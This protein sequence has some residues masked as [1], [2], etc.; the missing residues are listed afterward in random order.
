MVPIYYKRRAQTDGKNNNNKNRLCKFYRKKRERGLVC[1]WRPTSI[2]IMY[3]YTRVS[4]S[5]NKANSPNRI[6]TSFIYLLFFF[7]AITMG[8][9]A[10]G[11]V[12]VIICGG[13]RLYRTSVSGRECNRSTNSTREQDVDG[14]GEMVVDDWKKAL[15]YHIIYVTCV[16]FF[17]PTTKTSERWIRGVELPASAVKRRSIVRSVMARKRTGRW[18]GTMARRRRETDIIIIL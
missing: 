12:C 17:H 4:S 3:I 2:W 5:S 1:V 7:L 9:Y 15:F 18:E 13:C 14:V 11:R 6:C 16:Y 10:C 8:V